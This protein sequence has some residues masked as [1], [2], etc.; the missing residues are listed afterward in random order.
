MYPNP[1]NGFFTIN[2]SSSYSEPARVVVTNMMGRRVKEI[3][4]AAN[5]PTEVQLDAPPGVYFVNAVMEDGQRW[6]KQRW[7]RAQEKFARW[8]TQSAP[9]WRRSVRLVQRGTC[10]SAECK[11]RGRLIAAEKASRA[12]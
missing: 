9:A 10:R 4:V 7:R 5:Q 11:P 2:I 3:A 1:S 12:G 6:C 8:G